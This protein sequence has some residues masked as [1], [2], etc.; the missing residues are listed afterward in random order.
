MS[1]P[2]DLSS[3]SLSS[4]RLND[5]A[6]YSIGGSGNVGGGSYFPS[7]PPMQGPFATMG[8]S[9]LKSR[10]SRA[11][12]PSVSGAI[13]LWSSTDAD[14]IASSHFLINTSCVLN[15][16]GSTPRRCQRGARFRHI[17]QICHLSPQAEARPRLLGQASRS[18]THN[19]ACPC[20]RLRH[21]SPTTRLS[22]RRL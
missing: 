4:Q 2:P 3:L 15:S 13:I 17:I 1:S 14:D 5:H 18:L 11:G 22:R 20:P 8:A 21:R 9:P 12:L 7:A 19:T 6:D 16:N 10:P